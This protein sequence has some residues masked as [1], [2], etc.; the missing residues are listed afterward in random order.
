MVVVGLARQGKALTRYL[1]GQGAHVVLTDMKPKEALE[2]A[3][4][5]LQG[6]TVEL[7]LGGHPPELLEDVDTL[8][9]SGGVP[10]DHALAH[11]AHS[12]GIKVSNDSQLFLELCPAATI[13]ITG[14]AGKTTTTALVGS[15]AQVH[16]EGTRRRV[17]VGGNIG[18]PLLSDLEQIEKEDIAILELSSFQLELMTLSPQVAAVLNI[19]PNHL[20]RHHTL[21]LYAAAKARILDFQKADDVAVL[22][23]EDPGTWL[24]RQRVAGELMTFGLAEP[25]DG[26]AAYVSREAIWLRSAG[27]V[28][29]VGP[30]S[31]VSLRGGHNLLNVLAA[32]AIAACVGITPQA[33]RE[34]IRDFRGLAHRLEFVR[35]VRDVDWYNDSIATAPERAIAAMRA[36]KEPLVLLAGGRDKELPWEAFAEM[37]CRRVRHLIL[38]GEA[39]DKIAAAI[40]NVPGW[41]ASLS[42]ERCASLDEAV[43]AAARAAKPGDVVLLAPGG[44]SFDQFTDFEDRGDR[45]RQLVMEL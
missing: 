21:E 9:L 39:A 32:C 22:N 34:A 13:G 35:R 31:E 15:M 8:F 26:D 19:T 23:R 4:D 17:W 28:Q 3:L 12:Q 36:F 16:V 6:V 41:D 45:F 14:S 42:L 20:D 30:L 27:H 18:R 2:D 44:T 43:L 1:V 24:L 25:Q 10:A 5:E 37:A 33:M 11:T 29:P 40:R 38:F 7:R